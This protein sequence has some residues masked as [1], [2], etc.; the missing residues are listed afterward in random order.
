MPH[1]L[2]RFYLGWRAPNY[3]DEENGDGDTTITTEDLS[4]TDREETS[5]SEDIILLYIEYANIIITGAV[6]LSRTSGKIFEEVDNIN[7]FR[8]VLISEISKQENHIF[9]QQVFKYFHQYLAKTVDENI[10]YDDFWQMITRNRREWEVPKIIADNM[11]F[12]IIYS[13]IFPEHEKIIPTKKEIKS[14][15]NEEDKKYIE[16]SNFRALLKAK[17]TDC[18]LFIAENNITEK[19]PQIIQERISRVRT[20]TARQL[21]RDREEELL[22]TILI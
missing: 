10:K 21:S 3:P 13:K 17:S 5:I 6:E 19:L 4:D 22:R 2:S 14:S 11:I 8:D 12:L 15:Q 1:R 9:L 16:F 20:P 18:D 7:I